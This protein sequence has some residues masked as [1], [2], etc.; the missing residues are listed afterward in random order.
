M[1]GDRNAWALVGSTARTGTLRMVMSRA[2]V[3]VDDKA[4]EANIRS[5]ANMA[6]DR[7]K[8]ETTLRT[9]CNDGG[10][11]AVRDV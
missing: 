3:R 5:E 8:A 1:S 6:G 7:C 10:D 4:D 2:G 11:R 9:D